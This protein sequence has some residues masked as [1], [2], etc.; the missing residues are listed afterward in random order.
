MNKPKEANTETVR[1]LTIQT[2]S[3]S[4]FYIFYISNLGKGKVIHAF[5]SGAKTRSGR[6]P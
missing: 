6:G 3:N 5:L 4:T 2:T 1:K